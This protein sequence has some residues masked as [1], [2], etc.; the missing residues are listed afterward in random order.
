MSEKFQKNKLQFISFLARNQKILSP[1]E[2]SK[3]FEIN[4]KKVCERTIRRWF[5]SLQKSSEPLDYYPVPR[6]EKFGFVYS[7]VLLEN[8]NANV[9]DLIKIIPYITF[10]LSGTRLDS[11]KESVLVAYFTPKDN[12]KDFEEFWRRA[13]ALNL[14]GSFTIFHAQRTVYFYSKL[15]ETFHKGVAN[16]EVEDDDYFHKILRSSLRKRTEVELDPYIKKNPLA[17]AIISEHFKEQWPATKVWASAKQKLGDGIWDYIRDI[18]ARLKRT[19]SAGVKFVR[20]TFKDLNKD[21]ETFFQQ[22]KLDYAPL[23]LH[24]NN[25]FAYILLDIKEDKV[26]EFMKNSE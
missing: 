13:R 18:H 2:I 20:E 24:K 10:F 16:F 4:G 3:A 17:M 9:A 14:I 1:E 19:D 5:R 25:L 21:F 26:P 7:W 22:V 6:Y 12:I 23:W 15:H 8:V 11:L